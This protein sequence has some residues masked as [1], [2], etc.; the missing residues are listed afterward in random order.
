ML[1]HTFNFSGLLSSSLGQGHSD[2]PVS[3][4]QMSHLDRSFWL[5]VAAQETGSSRVVCELVQL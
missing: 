2:L 5:T 1:K 3:Y 4:Q